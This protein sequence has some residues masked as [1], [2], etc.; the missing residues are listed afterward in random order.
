MASP[1]QWTWVWAT[2][3]RWW[4]TGKPGVLQF[5]RL[6]RVR[7]DWVTKHQ[8]HE[9]PP[10]CSWENRRHRWEDKLAS[11]CCD[12]EIP[13]N[14]R[15]KNFVSY[16]QKCALRRNSILNNKNFKDTDS[17]YEK[18]EFRSSVG[19]HGDCVVKHFQGPI[20]SCWNKHMFK[21]L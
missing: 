9:E 13:E 19:T 5:T 17:M 8:L 6:Q 3:G 14:H 21:H 2:L 15:K 1:T 10:H 4:R 20:E 11:V 16:Y 7:H 18:P 12:I